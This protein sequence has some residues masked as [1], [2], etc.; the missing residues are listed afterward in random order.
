MFKIALAV[1]LALLP[2]LAP[3]AGE[4]RAGDQEL[5]AAQ[6][7]AGLKTLRGYLEKRDLEPEAA[8]RFIAVMATALPP[9]EGQRVPVTQDVFASF[10]RYQAAWARKTRDAKNPK[11]SPEQL[12]LEAARAVRLKEEFRLKAA[13][14]SPVFYRV[15]QAAVREVRRSPRRDGKAYAGSATVFFADQVDPSYTHVDAGDVALENGDTAAAVAEADKALALNPGN[16]D[17]LVLRAGAEYESGDGEAAVRDAQSALVLDPENRQAKAILSLSGTDAGRA[18]LAKAAAGEERTAASAAGPPSATPAVGAL[19]SRDLTAR[20]VGAA[21]ADA[22]SSIDELDQALLLNPRNAS[23]R[24]WRTAILN[25]IGDYASA[26]TSAQ[27]TLD[28]SPEDAPAYFHKAYAL[29]G[30]GDKAG[31]L[32]AIGRAAA[33]DRAYQPLKDK[34]LQ[35]PDAGDMAL[36][37]GEW[38]ESHP[39]AL[40]PARPSRYPLPLLGLGAV[41]GL[42]ALAG[43]AQLF[44]KGR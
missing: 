21:K 12:A 14:S 26:L 18:A 1:S 37:F 6:Y 39:Q 35:L 15:F 32:E 40:P 41:G 17:A 10:L 23:A 42:L 9:S 16:A 11:V 20:A 27:S 2:T 43:V 4:P 24:G 30:A 22:R 31:A 13:A 29:A 44:R 3:A 34:A 28:A 33:L 5:T 19:L 7:H 36:A 25:R 38:S 8:E